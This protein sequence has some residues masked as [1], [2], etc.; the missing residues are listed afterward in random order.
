MVCLWYLSLF[1]LTCTYFAVED[2]RDL[3]LEGLE[4]KNKG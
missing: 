3:W 4:Y 1:L 2:Q